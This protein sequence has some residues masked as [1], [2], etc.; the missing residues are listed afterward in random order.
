MDRTIDIQTPRRDSTPSFTE[1]W[2]A[3]AVYRIL[4][5][6]GCGGHPM[7]HVHGGSRQGFQ[8][9]LPVFRLRWLLGFPGGSQ[10]YLSQPDIS[11][12]TS[13]VLTGIRSSPTLR[14]KTFSTSHSC[15]LSLCRLRASET[16]ASGSEH[17]HVLSQS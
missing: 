12:A 4:R 11:S 10:R 1:E 5:Q 15:E 6:N 3:E 2:Q 9:P 14:S 13:S 16:P 17:I 7:K 8:C